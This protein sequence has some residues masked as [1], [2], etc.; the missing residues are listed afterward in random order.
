VSRRYVD[1][2]TRLG[3]DAAIREVTAE[4][5]EWIGVLIETHAK[6]RHDEDFQRRMSAP[7]DEPDPLAEWFQAGQ[8]K[9]VF[10]SDV[11]ALELGRFAT[12]VLNGV[13]LR[14]AAGDEF[15]VEAVLRVL[16]DGL[17]PRQ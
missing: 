6:L 9:G 3:L 2:L 8:E 12:I 16:H 15:D 14:V 1:L 11:S 7:A 10:R 5:P 4:N 17:G 13:A